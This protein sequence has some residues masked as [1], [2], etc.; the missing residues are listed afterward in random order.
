LIRTKKDWL[1]SKQVGV[2]F[3]AALARSKGLPDTPTTVEL[4]LTQDDRAA[5]ALYTS[6]AEV[7]RPLIGTPGIPADRLK[8][9]REAFMAATADPELVTE[10]E[11]AQVDFE[12]APGEVLQDLARKIAETPRDVVERTAKALQTR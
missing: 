1:D 6:S 10:I 9:L 12:P 8:T 3:Q 11:K 2:L 7:S 5:I 4:G